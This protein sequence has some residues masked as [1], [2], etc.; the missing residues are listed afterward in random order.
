MR[1]FSAEQ[2]ARLSSGW[3]LFFS[4]AEAVGLWQSALE[5]AGAKYRGPAVWVK[6]DSSPQFSGDKPAVNFEMMVLAWCGRGRSQWN[7]GG[8]RGT[9]Q[10]NVNGR[11]RDG[12]HPTEKPISLML[13][14]LSDFTN[15][16]DTILDP[17]MGSGSVGV[18]CLATGRSY[19]GI[20]RD[21]EYFR[22][23]CDRL[24]TANGKG[25]LFEAANDNQPSLPTFG[26]AEAV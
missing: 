6:P 21:P 14:L 16:Q 20:E 23:A 1:R 5:S 4:Q 17:F 7:G 15:P 24:A 18:A 13:E 22:V 26:L 10:H 12:R 2:G 8:K 25:S 9:Y 11:G 3:A 19:I